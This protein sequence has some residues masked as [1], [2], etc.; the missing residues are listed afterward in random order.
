MRQLKFGN[1]IFHIGLNTTVRFGRKWLD[2]TMG[3]EV[4]LTDTQGRKIDTGMVALLHVCHLADLPKCVTDGEHD[5]A[6]HDFN[7]L[8][9]VMEF[10][11]SECNSESEVVTVGFIPTGEI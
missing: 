10:L 1:P 3:E 7:E 9:R 8:L 4:E 5:P 11:Y 6:C 2:L